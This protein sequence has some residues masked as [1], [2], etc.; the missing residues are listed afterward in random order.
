[1]NSTMPWKQCSLKQK[2]KLTIVL[3]TPQLRNDKLVH[4]DSLARIGLLGYDKGKC[5]GQKFNFLPS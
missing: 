3:G 2:G 4:I 1:M 5:C